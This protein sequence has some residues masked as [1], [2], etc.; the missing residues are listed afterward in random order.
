MRALLRGERQA[1]FGVVLGLFALLCLL[2]S[3]LGLTLAYRSQLKDLK[4]TIYQRC[5]QRTTYDR[6]NHNAVLANEDLYA[7]LVKIAHQQ[8]VPRGTDPKLVTLYQRQV[9]ALELAQQRA[10]TA[11]AAGVVG[12]CNQ[13]R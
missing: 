11:A 3:S 10:H 2:S 4:S 5:L 7:T 8:P 6:A 13:Y 12:S 9:A 1:S